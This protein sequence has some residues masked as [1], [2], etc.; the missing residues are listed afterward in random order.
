MGLLVASSLPAATAIEW[1]EGSGALIPD[2]DPAALAAAP[3]MLRRWSSNFSSFNPSLLLLEQEE[4]GVSSMALAFFRVSNMHFCRGGSW[5]SGRSPP[6]RPVA[7]G[8]VLPRLFRARAD[9]AKCSR[10]G[11]VLRC[12]PTTD[13]DDDGEANRVWEFSPASRPD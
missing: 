3:S 1:L 10:G 5:R 13:D 4:N 12:V 9:F 2:L 8:G 7:G 6:D 11:G